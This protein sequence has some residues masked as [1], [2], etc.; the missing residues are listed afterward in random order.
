M[1][2]SNISS[3]FN[4]QQHTCLLSMIYAIARLCYTGG[5]VNNG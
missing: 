3:Y 5:L 4:P 2:F 1:I